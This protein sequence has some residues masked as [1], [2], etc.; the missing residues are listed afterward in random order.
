MN[1][2]TQASSLKMTNT[3]F[4][5]QL[6]ADGSYTFFSP[7][8]NEFFHSSFGAKQEA[9]KKFIEPC[10]I[11]QKALQNSTIKLLDICYGLGYNTATALETIW[12]VN[13]NCSVFVMALELDPC[14][15]RQAI[16]HQLLT[17][18]SFPIPDLLT[19]LAETGQVTT[20]NLQAQLIWGDARIGL[21]Q[22][23]QSG[24]KADAIFLDP[25][26]P[27][28]CPQLWTVQ[29]LQLM[30][31][32]LN[33]TGR[34]ATYSC[35]ASVRTALQLAGLTI[36]S[37]Q[38]VGRRSPGTLASFSRLGAY[39][40]CQQELEHLNT[41]AAIPYQ[42]PELEDSV[43]LIIERREKE[44]QSSSLEP[45]SHWKKRWTEPH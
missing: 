12:T 13:P 20:P 31:N 7:E 16:N 9:Q 28:K 33:P 6:T 34:V 26:S 2:V 15:P 11:A 3:N 32:C 39:P 21:S 44:Q 8:F 40:L 14:V 4:D 24:F 29:F 18:F 22:V 43:T 10:Q 35:A 25:F 23:Y 19:I 37:T 1:M 45:T 41:K 17:S 30:A 5:P 36:G 38:P 42:D 27:T